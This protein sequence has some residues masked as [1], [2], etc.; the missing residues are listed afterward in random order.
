MSIF[1]LT[2]IAAIVSMI[3][4]AVWYMPLFGKHWAK[5]TG[6]EHRAEDQKPTMKTMAGPL[7]LNFVSNVLMS[8]VVFLIL[9]GFGAA[10]IS[11][12]L[13]T[14]AVLFVGFAIPFT[15]GSVMWKGFSTKQQLQQF[16]ISA[17]FQLINF[18]VWAL[19]FVWL[20]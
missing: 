6:R 3:L 18:A 13:I 19:I 10:T 5:A 11:Q 16:G 7:A 12:A 1:L 8:F 17:G 4:G 2:L 20:M 15:V 9:A 14:V